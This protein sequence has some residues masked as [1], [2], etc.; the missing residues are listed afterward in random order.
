MCCFRKRVMLVRC[1][2]IHISTGLLEV[3]I[4]IA[5]RN[6][7]RGLLF[8]HEVR[9]INESLKNGGNAFKFVTKIQ[10]LQI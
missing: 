9:I 4:M 10:P 2:A 1:Y 7:S 6:D 3:R 5:L 8:N